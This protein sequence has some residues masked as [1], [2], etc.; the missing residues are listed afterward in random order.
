MAKLTLL[1]RL[2]RDGE[3]YADRTQVSPGPLRDLLADIRACRLCLEA[4]LQGPLPHAPRPVL[5]VSATARLFISGQAPG[6]RVH[7]S[8]VPFTDPSGDR[9]RDWM[10]IDH[11]TFYDTAQVAVVP[12]GFCFP[13]YDAK[14]SDLPPRRECRAAWHDRLFAA[15]PQAETILAIGT[16]AQDYHFARL[17]I[18]RPKGQSVTETVRNWRRGFEMTPHLIAL[19]HPSWRNTGWLKQNPW[20][21]KEVLPILRA[22]VA[23]LTSPPPV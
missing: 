3:I 21:E 23:R 5:R 22:E 19:P 18:P 20:F 7:K 11:A 16:Y 2:E 9:L 6:L 13:G 17:G 15:L 1:Q 8:G 14:G 4:P 10:G 12:M